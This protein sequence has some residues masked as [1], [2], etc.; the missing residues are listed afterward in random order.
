MFPRPLEPQPFARIV[1]CACGQRA[2]RPRILADEDVDIFRAFRPRL[3][4]THRL[5]RYAGEQVGRDHRLP[6]VVHLAPVEQL[7]AL[8]AREHADMAH[9]EGE[10][11][12]GGDAAEPRARARRQRQRIIACVGGGIEQNVTQPHLGKRIALFGQAQEDIGFRTFDIRGDDR[13]AGLQGQRL[14][15][16]AGRHRLSALD[17]D[18]PELVAIAGHGRNHHAQRLPGL[19]RLFH[20]HRGGAVVITFRAQDT[21]GERLVLART[22]GD[23]GAVGCLPVRVFQRRKPAEAPFQVHF[24]QALDRERVADARRPGFIRLGAGRRRGDVERR[25]RRQRL[26]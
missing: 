16:E 5:G 13:I 25:D 26:G 8:E 7:A 10:V 24:L 23:L 18:G 3:A 19:R 21:D 11:A 15:G 2:R 22:G 1:A 17:G 20:R 4:R 9:V 12:L 6:E 14:P